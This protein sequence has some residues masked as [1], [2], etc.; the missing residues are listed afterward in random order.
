MTI[1]L[2]QHAEAKPESEDPERSLTEEGVENAR[3]MAE[4]AALANVHVDEVRHS[5]KKRAQQTAE[6]L[7]EALRPSGGVNAVDGLGP[8][9]DVH[10]I[11]NELQKEERSVMLVGHLPFLARLAGLLLA[12]RPEAPVVRFRNAGIVCLD[13]DGA[14]SVSWTMIPHLML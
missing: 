4:W 5:G 11:A 13:L 7:A 3:R 6:I 10:P 8:N 2:V 9:D 1:Y 12:G 14:W